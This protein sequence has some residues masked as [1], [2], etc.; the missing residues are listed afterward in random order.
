M[1]PWTSV[2]GGRARHGP[3]IGRQRPSH[4]ESIACPLAATTLVF[5]S[6]V[7]AVLG[8]F[9]AGNLVMTG[10]GMLGVFGA[11]LLEI[12]IRGARA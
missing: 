2:D 11:G 5:I 12:A 1:R 7:V 9:V 4:L 10:V 6:A 3:T 8:L